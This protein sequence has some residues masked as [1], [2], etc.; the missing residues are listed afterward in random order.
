[1]ALSP[2][3]H[4]F[5][6]DDHRTFAEDIRK[7]FS[8]VSRYE[9]TVS[10]NADDL[11]RLFNT[12]KS[13]KVCK[14]VIIGLH[15]SK[16]NYKSTENFIDRL[17]K[18]D[19]G[20][21]ILLIASPDKIDDARKALIFNVDALIPRNSNTVLRVHNAVKKHISE[22][23]LRIFRRR[24]NISIAVLAASLIFALL[25]FLAARIRFPEYF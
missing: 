19:P 11:F 2:K 18:S 21:G 7:R 10:Y 3:T 13:W 22:H 6:L 1:M 5:C 24:R 17:K 8:D 23:N 25:I 14:V 20:A 4:I 9:V 15:D 16:E 12:V